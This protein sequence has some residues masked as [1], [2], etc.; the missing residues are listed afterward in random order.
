MNSNI[1]PTNLELTSSENNIALT[2]GIWSNNYKTITYD[3]TGLIESTSY[4][5]NIT[6]NKII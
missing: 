4:T 6:T 2:T 5:L 3:I 1:I